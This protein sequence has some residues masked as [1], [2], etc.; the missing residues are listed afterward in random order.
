[1]PARKLSSS[2]STRPVIPRHLSLSQSSSTKPP[3]MYPSPSSN[4]ISDPSSTCMSVFDGAPSSCTNPDTQAGADLDFGDAPNLSNPNF[5]QWTTTTK[6]EA[7]KQMGYY[8]WD[9]INNN[10]FGVDFNYRHEFE[11]QRL[12]L[13]LTRG[14]GLLHSRLEKNWTEYDDSGNDRHYYYVLWTEGG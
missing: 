4:P 3:P 1:M 12:A 2:N 14:R 9:G 6:D 11:G 10:G 8:L 5:G 13:P 7:S